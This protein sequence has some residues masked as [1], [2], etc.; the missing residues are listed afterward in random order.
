MKRTGAWIAVKALEA[1]GIRYTFG[2][3]GVHNT[4][5]YDELNSSEKITPVLVTHEGGASF[6]ADGVSRTSDQTGT[7]VIVPAAGATHAA[8]GIGEAFLDGIPMLVICGGIRTDLDKRYQLHELDQHAFLKPLTKASFLVTS[9]AEI[10][11]T[12]FKAWEIAHRR[13]GTGLRRDSGQPPDVSRRGAGHS[14]RA[15]H[16]QAAAGGCRRAPARRRNA[17]GGQAAGPVHRLGRARRL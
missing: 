5:L 9:H 4:E 15:S 6:M 14:R 1:L 12:L 8:S 10:V 13:A 11:P 16:R 7:L 3:P 2:I 17:A